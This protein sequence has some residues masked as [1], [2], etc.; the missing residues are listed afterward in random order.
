LWPYPDHRPS[1]RSF[2]LNTLAGLRIARNLG[3]RAVEFDNNSP[4]RHTTISATMILS[5]RPTAEVAETS[6]RQVN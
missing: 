1:R 2:W 4:G 5:G 6:G 3:F